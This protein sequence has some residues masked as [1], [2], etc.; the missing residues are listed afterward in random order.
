MRVLFCQ[1]H[2]DSEAVFISTAYL[3][4]FFTIQEKSIQ[5]IVIGQEKSMPIILIRRVV[6]EL[7]LGNKGCM[8]LQ[9]F[10]R[11]VNNEKQQIGFSAGKLNVDLFLTRF[12]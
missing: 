7:P 10:A 6:V 4:A 5:L 8:I 12:G 11:F 2:G 1:E 3:P 9:K